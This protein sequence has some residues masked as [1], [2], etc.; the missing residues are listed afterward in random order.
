[1]PGM[2]RTPELLRN[3]GF[4]AYKLDEIFVSPLVVELVLRR[5]L[6]LRPRQEETLLR[7][8]R[9]LSP[10]ILRTPSGIYCFPPLLTSDAP[11]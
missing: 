3:G 1:M 7:I 10:Q 2:G 4:L 6:S 11:P 8:K 5:L 9:P